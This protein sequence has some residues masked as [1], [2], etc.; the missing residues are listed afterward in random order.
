MTAL[1]FGRQIGLNYRGPDC[2]AMKRALARAGF[3]PKKLAGL[4][5]VFGPY[6]VKELERFQADQGIAAD[7]VYGALTHARLSQFFDSRAWH[8]Y[9]EVHPAGQIQ[10]PAVFTSTHETSGLDGYPAVDVFA[11]GGT[12]ALAPAAGEIHKLSGHE[13][14][15][16]TTP[17][18][19]Y[20]WSIYLRDASG[21]DYFLTH[22][23]TRL[24]TLN[25]V[26][27]YGQPLGTVSDYTR[28]TNGVTPSHIHEG[29]HAA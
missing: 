26:V 6:A 11:P 10:L 15:A 7:G 21:N 5:R 4:T 27:K 23:G 13:P 14:T 2:L 12:I 18:G 28:A 8:L 17:G 16:S 3:G 22:F 19:P 1:P 25:E 24:V 9:A 29:K 20:G